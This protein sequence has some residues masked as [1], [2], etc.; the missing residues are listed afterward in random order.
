MR[1]HPGDTVRNRALEEPSCPVFYIGAG[2][3]RPSL[4]GSGNGI[5]EGARAEKLHRKAAVRV[6]MQIDKAG[7]RE[8]SRLTVRRGFD[9]GDFAVAQAQGIHAR[10]V[11]E[12]DSV[13]IHLI[14]LRAKDLDA[15]AALERATEA[16]LHLGAFVGHGGRAQETALRFNP[17][18]R[19]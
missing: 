4:G 1:A 13:E 18:D 8:P 5:G 7:K 11:R 15:E 9:S 3:G 17:Q 12:R 10:P 19:E 16:V 6:G 14:P 2:E